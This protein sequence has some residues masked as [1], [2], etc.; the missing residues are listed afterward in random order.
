MEPENRTIHTVPVI[1]ETQNTSDWVSALIPQIEQN[2]F[3][4]SKAEIKQTNKWNNRKKRLCFIIGIPCWIAIAILSTKLWQYRSIINQRIQVSKSII[5][6][7]QESGIYTIN[8]TTSLTIG[9]K[10]INNYNF[11]KINDDNEWY[12]DYSEEKN[13]TLSSAEYKRLDDVYSLRHYILFDFTF[14][15][16]NLQNRKILNKKT[17]EDLWDINEINWE[18]L[19]G[20]DNLKYLSNYAAWEEIELDDDEGIYNDTNQN[21]TIIIINSRWKEK[22]T[23]LWKWKVYVNDDF[24]GITIKIK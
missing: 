2:K 4:V 10:T 1:T 5:S 18:S 22:E 7:N 23:K 3:T 15:N 14:S 19:I 24:R 13:L 11:S 9:S 21:H 8:W 6:Q 20:K 12:Y 17:K 16:W